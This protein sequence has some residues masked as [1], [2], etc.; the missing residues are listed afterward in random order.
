MNGTPNMCIPC[1][2]VS[3][4]EKPYKQH[5]KLIGK[6]LVLARIHVII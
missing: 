3:M 4:Y 6:I 5:I 2:D 1:I